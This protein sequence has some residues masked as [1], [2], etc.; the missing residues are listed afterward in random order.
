[1]IRRL[2]GRFTAEGETLLPPWVAPV[3]ALLCVLLVPWTMWTL[4]T[5]PDRA[6][7]DHW[8]IVWGGFDLALAASFAFMVTT[9]VRRSTWTPV[10]ASITATLLVCDAWFDVLTAH[11]MASVSVSIAEALL[12]ELPL[13]AICL[14]VARDIERAL[15]TI[16]P[17]IFEAGFTIRDRRLVPPEPIDVATEATVSRPEPRG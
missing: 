13:A 1:M 15:A 10:S 16:V 3:F 4:Y 7:A 6:L 2:I 5:L 17:Y 8:R 9:I 14:L 11:G 12:V